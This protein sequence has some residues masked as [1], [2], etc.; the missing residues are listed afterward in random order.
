MARCSRAA[1]PPHIRAQRGS[2]TDVSAEAISAASSWECEVQRGV[3]EAV[4]CIMECTLACTMYCRM[5]LDA[6]LL[7]RDDRLSL[8]GER[9]GLTAAPRALPWVLRGTGNPPESAEQLSA[10]GVHPMRRERRAVSLLR[11]P[12]QHEARRCPHERGARGSL[13]CP[14]PA[15]LRTHRT[16]SLLHS[17]PRPPPT[18][19]PHANPPT[20]RPA[21]PPARQPANPSR[22]ARPHACTHAPI[23][24]PITG[25][26]ALE[27]GQSAGTGAERWNADKRRGPQAAGGVG[28]YTAMRSRDAV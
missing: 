9:W 7:E 2:G 19:L 14:P 23:R 13:A 25:G 24:A 5:R 4:W 21:S 12:C 27:R 11:R 15:S 10:Q 26:R 6:E 3:S 1:A 28:I 17:L 8:G 18:T 16:H 22:G 20:R